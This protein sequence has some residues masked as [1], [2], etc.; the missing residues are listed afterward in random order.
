M[1]LVAPPDA[2]FEHSLKPRT[3]MLADQALAA[4]R[5]DVDRKP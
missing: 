4:L 2:S 3:R 1:T 5:A